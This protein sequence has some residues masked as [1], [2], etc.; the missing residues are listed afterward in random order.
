MP[1]KT[2]ILLILYGLLLAALAARSGFVLL[3]AVPF[4]VYLAVGLLTAPSKVRL[5]AARV[6]S[7]SRRRPTLPLEVKVTISNE[8]PTLSR[9][10]LNDL[11]LPGLLVQDGYRRQ[12][13][14]VEAGESFVLEYQLA[15]RRG[16]FH[17]EAVHASASD[18]FGLYPQICNLSSPASLLIF[19][20]RK[21]LK[22]IPLRPKSMLQASGPYPARRSGAGLDF[23][24]VRTYRSGDPLRWVCWRLSARYPG[25]F[26]SKEF[27]QEDIAD[28]GLIFDG[29][30]FN[31]LSGDQD[32]LFE[33]A[34]EAA[35]SFAEAFLRGGNRVALL[36]LGQGVSFV[37][38][39]SGKRQLMLILEHLAYA[40]PGGEASFASQY[41][42]PVR[43]F[44]SRSLIVVVS[45]LG[46]R[47]F[48]TYQRLRS[49]GYQLLLFSPD[50]LPYAE[51]ALPKDRLTELAL[52]TARLERRLQIAH[53]KQLGVEVIEW[54][55][56]QPLTKTIDV[57]L[58]TPRSRVRR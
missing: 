44:P 38:P 43:L 31:G 25:K 48:Q 16:S 29:P 3:L 32:S 36:G 30:A 18:P 10:E 49:H 6:V 2:F 50:P 4:W 53:L 47:D 35:A 39:G 8:G 7:Y 26:F 52:K 37:F 13:L 5:S 40:R 20:Q 42:L 1:K 58:R 19:P 9:L 51:A 27:E 11:E 15:P 46:R 14:A 41:F 24:G 56:D 28:I 55:V 54:Q 17:W 45:P 12:S 22:H 34:V 21:K 57:A 33:H 23:W